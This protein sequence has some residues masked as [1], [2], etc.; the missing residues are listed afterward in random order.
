MTLGVLERRMDKRKEEVL[1][2]RI[3]R[4][5]RLAYEE[6]GWKPPRGEDQNKGGDGG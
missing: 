2:G 1:H 6:P 5:R 3:V 4:D